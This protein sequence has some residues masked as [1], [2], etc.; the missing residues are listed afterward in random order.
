MKNSMH[1]INLGRCK[2]LNIKKKSL[3]EKAEQIIFSL[4]LWN[5]DKKHGMFVISNARSIWELMLCNRNLAKLV[6]PTL[7]SSNC[8]A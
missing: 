8:R 3:G 4:N 6:Y 5:E 1:H 2:L 7:L